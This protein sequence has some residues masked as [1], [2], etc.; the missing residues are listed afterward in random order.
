MDERSG[1]GPA[2]GVDLTLR[3]TA[4]E[5]YDWAVSEEQSFDPAPDTNLP[6]PFTVA[7]PTA[8][9]IDTRDVTF[10]GVTLKQPK[11]TWTAPADQFVVSGGAIEVQWKLTSESDYRPSFTVPG[12]ETEVFLS[13][14]VEDGTA[15]DV[16]I[17]S[18]NSIGIRADTFQTI[19]NHTVGGTASGPTFEDWGNFSDSPAVD[20]TEDWGDF[21]SSPAVDT[22]EDWG[23]F[24]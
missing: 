16:R 18:I 8:L 20:T 21:S 6:D 23:D 3:E 12:N 17:R 11:L 22:T 9:N 1:G 24:T 5:V 19:T 10:G 2:F 15:I 13:D 4:A 14:L 7:N